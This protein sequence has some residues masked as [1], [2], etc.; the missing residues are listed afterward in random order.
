MLFDIGL[1]NNFSDT[2][3]KAQATKAKIK[4]GHIKLECFC[5]TVEKNPQN[6]KATY[7]MEK[8]MFVNHNL[9]RG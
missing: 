3:P 4:Q 2:T 1:G 5:T 7:A 8:K 9:I 6:E